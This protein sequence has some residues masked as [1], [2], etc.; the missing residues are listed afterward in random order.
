M[1]SLVFSTL[2]TPN[3]LGLNPLLG[4]QFEFAPARGVVKLLVRSNQTG[5]RITIYTGS[6]TIQERSP[7]QGGGTPGITPSELNTA[8]QQWVAEAGDRLKLLIDEVIGGAPT[9]DGIIVYEPF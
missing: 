1:P 9:V 8:A 5:N 3:Q 4:W 7:V 6:T 2:M